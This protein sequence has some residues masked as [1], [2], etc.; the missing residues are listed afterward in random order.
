MR[1]IMLLLPLVVA[2]CNLNAD[3][4]STDVLASA[5]S[6]LDLDM[7]SPDVAPGTDVGLD[8][9]DP[10]TDVGPDAVAPGTDVGPDAV[11][12]RAIPADQAFLPEPLVGKKWV[13]TFNDEFDGTTLDLT[14]WTRYGGT[15][16]SPQPRR[17]GYWVH[18]AVTLDG[19]GHAAITTFEKDGK[20][21]DGGFGTDG[22]FNQAFGYW[23]ARVLLQKD[24]GHWFGWWL[25]PFGSSQQVP[26]GTDGAEIDI[27]ET[28][29]GKVA[30]SQIQSAV[31]WDMG[32]ADD[33]K[34]RG[35]NLG[36]LPPPA[37]QT[38]FHTLAVWWRSDMYIF[39][40]DGVETWRTTVGG[41]CQVPE[42]A[43]LTDEISN[44]TW[45]MTDAIENA[46]LPDRTLI[47]YVRVFAL[48]DK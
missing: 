32:E 18:E 14:K 39:Y 37:D 28:P 26:G 11:D 20:Y 2:S 34:S 29:Y 4:S 40:L 13:M 16:D 48:E 38:A 8:A 9:V 25:M 44:S 12:P 33:A 10:G 15:M 47:D 22:K 7:A 6:T 27:A 17:D 23:E 1:R 30:P 36:T 45:V 31:H 46:K 35:V 41:V 3:A 43:I 5:D 24:E 42:Y 21:Y 19:M